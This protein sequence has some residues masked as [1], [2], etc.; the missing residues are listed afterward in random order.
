MRAV[1]AVTTLCVPVNGHC[2]EVRIPSGELGVALRELE[3]ELDVELI[4]V[5]EDVRGV[6]TLGVHG[7]L[8]PEEALE[9][10][11]AGTGLTYH[12]LDSKAI[13]IVPARAA[14]DNA[15]HSRPTQPAALEQVVVTAQKRTEYAQNVPVSVSVVSGATLEEWGATRLTD[16]AAYL[17]GLTVVPGAAPGE[18]ML[19][20]RGLGMPSES[21]LVGMYID[22]TPVGGSSDVQPTTRRALDLLPYD[23]ERIEVLEGPQGTLYGAN[24]MGGLVKYVT[25]KP[26]LESISARVGADFKE[27]DN[28]SEA[29]WDAHGSLNLPIVADKAAIRVGVSQDFTP[30]FV[31]A[32]EQ[33]RTDSNQVREEAGRLALLLQLSD[34]WS[35]DLATL[36]Q[37]LD[38]PDPAVVTLT[39][40][41]TPEPGRWSNSFQ[42]PNTF[43]SRLK[44]YSTRINGTLRWASFTSVTSFSATQSANGS[45]AGYPL[46]Q[47]SGRAAFGLQVSANKFTQELR[48]TSPA[49]GRLDWLLGAFYTHEQGDQLQAGYAVNPANVALPNPQINPE[50]HIFVPTSYQEYALFGGGTWK[51]T[52]ALDLTL[53]VRESRNEQTF[54]GIPACSPEYVTAIAPCPPVGAGSSHQNVFNFTVGP[55]YHFSPDVMVYFRAAS[56]YRPGAPNV[57]APH[58]PTSVAADTLVSSELGIKSTWLDRKLQINAAAYQVDWDRI[59]ILAVA[60]PPLSVTYSANGN[61]ATVRGFEAAMVYAPVGGIRFASSTVYTRA[62]LSAPMPSGSTLVGDRGD[63]LPY[64]SLWSGS[65]TADYSHALGRDWVG[66]LGA[67]WRYTG[68]RYTTINNPGNCPLNCAGTETVPRLRPYGVFDLHAGLSGERWNAR[69]AVR[70]LTN[71][72]ALVDMSGGGGQTFD[73]TPIGATV[74]SGRTFTLGI[75]RQF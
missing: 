74:L 51:L 63:S 21:A 66:A 1:I 67:G 17:S 3:K 9:R 55:S 44:Y 47:L 41:L 28:A 19:I 35:V 48:L 33:G 25:R 10:I 22:D 4:F 49:G 62:A 57:P 61:T 5:S 39:A 52:D 7:N 38:S 58:I 30:G 18:D 59:Q 50:V 73:P 71:K 45:Q 54:A 11:L 31:A 46:D 43:S 20:L 37:H 56:G 34:S 72:F 69:L 26:D 8:T 53:G 15:R 42:V 36:L 23:F 24:A 64:I 32:P 60:P 16:Y 65:L 29:G 12:S 2:K 6:R 27:N 14:D 68:P 75:D 70:N 13:T 40:R